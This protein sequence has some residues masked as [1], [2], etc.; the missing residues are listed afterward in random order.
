MSFTPG[1][2]L[3]HTAG[4]YIVRSS[5]NVAYCKRICSSNPTGDVKGWIE[6]T[7]L[8]SSFLLRSSFFLF[9]LEKILKNQKITEVQLTAV[10]G[11]TVVSLAVDFI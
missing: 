6:D 7:T 3:C 5:A 8:R 9:S 1:A 2:S 10:V 11:Q 4:A